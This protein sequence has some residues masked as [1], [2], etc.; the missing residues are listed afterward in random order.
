M[1]ALTPEK[2]AGIVTG[3]CNP[4]LDISAVVP[5]AILE[6]YGVKAGDAVLAEDKHQPVYAE[7]VKDYKVDYMA[8]GAPTGFLRSF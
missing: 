2:T 6:K 3:M 8:G 1:A 5:A 4:L 7:L